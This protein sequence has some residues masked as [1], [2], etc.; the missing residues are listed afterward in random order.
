MKLEWNNLEGKVIKDKSTGE[1]RYEILKTIG[2][3]GAGKVYLA[4]DLV[5]DMHVA[6]KAADPKPTMSNA[7]ERFEIEADILKK[8]HSPYVIEYFD[9]FTQDG[10]KMIVMEYVEG[11]SLDKKLS[12]EKTISPDEAIKFVRQLLEALDEV[13][14]HKVYHRD[15]KPENIHVTID[16]N[17]KLLDFGIVQ[18]SEDQNLTKQGA[19]IGTVSYMSPEII[20]NPYK[21]ASSRT[22]IYSVGVMTY[23]LL[24]GA[25][26]FNPND[27]LT[28]AEKNNNLALKIVKDNAIPPSEVD[29]NIPENLSHFVM[30]MIDKEPHDRYQNTKEALKDL[31]RIE[32]GE[33]IKSYDGFEDGTSSANRQ[34]IILSAIAA[35]FVIFFI[36][37]LVLAF[38]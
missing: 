13:H 2:K 7:L 31:K 15:I 21:K 26:P 1:D 9:N 29:G 28:G 24:T 6:I 16:G 32:S 20:L 34:L 36:I 27:G 25:K 35:S 17:I 3:G 37:A 23:E 4:H 38:I 30:R 8:V 33:D 14:S 22:D 19:V 10:I 12:N 5:E 11:I 18:E